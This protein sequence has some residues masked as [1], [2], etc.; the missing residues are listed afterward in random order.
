MSEESN[1]ALICR[2]IEEVV[3]GGNMELVDELLHE[4]YLG[5]G[6]TREEYKQDALSQ[7][8]PNGHH[9]VDSHPH[10]IIRYHPVNTIGNR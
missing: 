9:T 1:K 6:G 10:V 7:S 2:Y 5:V 8:F 4:N 3:N